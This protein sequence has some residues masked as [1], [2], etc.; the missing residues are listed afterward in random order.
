ML[1]SETIVCIEKSL[2]S[3]N[4]LVKLMDSRLDNFD[5]TK[6][7]KILE[8]LRKM[9]SDMDRM[10]REYGKYSAEQI[11]QMEIEM[12]KLEQ[13]EVL[14]RENLENIQ[15]HSSATAAGPD[16]AAWT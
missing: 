11:R 1:D 2:S 5:D 10:P 8:E 9:R 6:S 16:E 15:G 3:L 13:I 12:R 4:K 7:S 14:I